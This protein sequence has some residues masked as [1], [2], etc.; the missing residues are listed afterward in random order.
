MSSWNERSWSLKKKTFV[1]VKTVWQFFAVSFMA[2]AA[3]SPFTFTEKSRL[4][5]LRISWFARWF[6]QKP[7]SGKDDWFNQQWYFDSFMMLPGK[8]WMVQLLACS[9]CLFSGG[10]WYG[11]LDPCKTEIG[12]SFPRENQSS[13]GSWRWAMGHRFCQLLGTIL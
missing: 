1:S 3:L 13:I 8:I 11:E 9:W 10:S 5:Y 4:L 2:T 12:W 7:P 6:L